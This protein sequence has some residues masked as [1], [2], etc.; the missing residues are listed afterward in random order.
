LNHQCS[1]FLK[2]QELYRDETKGIMSPP[3]LADLNKD[4]SEDIVAA[5]F[6]SAVI[7]FNGLTL[8]PL[9]NFSFPGSETFG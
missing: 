6:N 5:M 1:V 4:G 8:Q 7:A 3:V 2:V 9:W